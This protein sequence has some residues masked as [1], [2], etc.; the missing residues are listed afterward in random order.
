MAPLPRRQMTAGR[1]KSPRRKLRR[2]QPPPP[3]RLTAPPPWL[4]RITLRLMISLPLTLPPW[5]RR[6]ASLFSFFSLWL[7]ITQFGFLTISLFLLD[8]LGRQAPPAR[9]KERRRLPK[10]SSS[11]SSLS[12]PSLT[13]TLRFLP[14]CH[15]RRRSPR[16][17]RTQSPPP[18]PLLSRMVKRDM[19][20]GTQQR[21]RNPVLV[22]MPSPPSHPDPPKS[23]RHPKTRRT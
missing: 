17:A 8:G 14:Q 18:P 10:G 23:P 7:N 5:S 4:A 22:R 13:P 6:M 20:D 12:S 11:S 1:S 9:P 3:Q 15:R 21:K 2:R 16:R 19:R